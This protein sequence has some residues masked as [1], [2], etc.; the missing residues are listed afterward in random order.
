MSDQ[1]QDKRI[2]N[3]VRVVVDLDVCHKEQWYCDKIAAEAVQYILSRQCRYVGEGKYY[4]D[5]FKD[6][7]FPMLI[8]EVKSLTKVE[9]FQ[10]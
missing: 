1:P 7:K 5:I 8:T 6:D 9:I 10:D 2:W 3:K 4:I